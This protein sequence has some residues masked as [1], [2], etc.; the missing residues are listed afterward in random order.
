MAL[1]STPNTGVPRAS[2]FA[3]RLGNTPQHSASVWTTFEATDRLQ[4]G[5]GGRHV[6]A[7]YSNTSNTREAKAYTVYDAMAAFEIS[8]SARVRVNG[9][10]LGDKDFVETVGGGHYT[11]GAGRS[12][13]AS[14][15]LSF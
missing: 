4:F 7:R 2:S 14:L 12:W 13:M 1:A 10:N 6:G 8:D 15:D 11:P 3:N 9:Y 5:L